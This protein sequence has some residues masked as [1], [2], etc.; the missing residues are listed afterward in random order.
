MCVLIT[1]APDYLNVKPTSVDILST[2]SLDKLIV[3]KF[4]NLIPALHEV[5]HWLDTVVSQKIITGA[6]NVAVTCHTISYSL[7]YFPRLGT[8]INWKSLAL[9]S[10][11]L[12]R[13]L[14]GED[15]GEPPPSSSG[16]SSSSSELDEKIFHCF[17]NVSHQVSVSHVF[18][19]PILF[20]SHL[21]RKKKRQAVSDDPSDAI[22]PEWLLSQQLLSSISISS[23]PT[24]ATP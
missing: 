13:S 20:T 23:Q 16:D 2:L 1:K 11:D 14:S 3:L 7:T 22:P 6:F 8:C 18:Q 10:S 19:S 9:C 15:S 17:K 4:R 12:T 21:C 5:K 24:K